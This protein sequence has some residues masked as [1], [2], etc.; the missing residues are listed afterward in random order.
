[1]SSTCLHCEISFGSSEVSSASLDSWPVAVLLMGTLNFSPDVVLYRHQQ[2]SI[3]TT[4]ACSSTISG[5]R[6]DIYILPGGKRG[7][8]DRWWEVEWGKLSKPKEEYIKQPF[9]NSIVRPGKTTLHC[10][11]LFF[12]AV[13]MGSSARTSHLTRLAQTTR[14]TRYLPAQRSTVSLGPVL[15]RGSLSG[16]DVFERAKCDAVIKALAQR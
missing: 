5:S 11:A 3:M 15:R 8:R 10:W 4:N 7:R 9:K 2:T 14:A 13:L 12:S 16:V 1:M 6:R